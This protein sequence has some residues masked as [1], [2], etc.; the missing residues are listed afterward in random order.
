MNIKERRTELAHMT[1]MTCLMIVLMLAGCNG[2]KREHGVPDTSTI[3]SVLQQ[4][5]DIVTT[6]VTIRKI[7]YYDTSLHE[8]V[9]IADPSTWRYGDRKCIVP[10]EIKI[11]YGYDLR[12]L[13][14]DN[15][16]VNDSLRSMEITLPD[17]KII[18]AGYNLEVDDDKVV[19]IS[20]GLRS[21]VG[22][23]T[24]EK[25]RTQAYQAVMKEDFQELVGSEIR[26]NAQIML[27]SLARSMG[28]DSCN[29]K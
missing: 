10:V 7:A 11:K 1:V 24:I 14:L 17:A 16:K 9:N 22:H 29:V 5:A 25:I 13:T 15:V 3:L 19:S 28:F 20:T 27:T 4:R 18:D 21:K 26:H 8:K 6:E 2:E 23:E 12:D